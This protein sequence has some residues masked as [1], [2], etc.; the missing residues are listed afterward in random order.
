V[1]FGWELQLVGR[2]KAVDGAEVQG[3]GHLT[4][5]E[6]LVHAVKRVADTEEQKERLF[7]LII[8]KGIFSVK[9]LATRFILCGGRSLILGI[10]GLDPVLEGAVAGNVAFFVALETL[11]VISRKG[12]N[13][14]C[15]VAP[16]PGVGGLGSP[17]KS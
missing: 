3:S 1:Y 14:F 13:W 9:E 15:M 12:M 4:V 8:K 17:R 16:V 6:R 2:V 11:L 10:L 7:E 5:L